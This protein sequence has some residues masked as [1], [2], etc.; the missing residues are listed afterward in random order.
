M[1]KK[2]VPKTVRSCL[3]IAMTLKQSDMMT[4]LRQWPQFTSMAFQLAR[5]VAVSARS[6][7]AYVFYLG[8]ESSQ[9]RGST[10]VAS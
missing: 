8:Q 9:E 5:P 1:T 6:E 3:S 10:Q 2:A 4:P 7:G